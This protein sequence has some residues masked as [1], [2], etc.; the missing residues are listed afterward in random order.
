MNVCFFFHGGKKRKTYT[1]VETIC[2]ASTN[3]RLTDFNPLYQI[4]ASNGANEYTQSS[5]Q[6]C[7]LQT[8]RRNI[9]SLDL[10]AVEIGDFIL[11]GFR[12]PVAA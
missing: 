8:G 10:G 2:S 9:G 5:A 1:S 12:I 7:I 4:F 11:V 6:N 3:S